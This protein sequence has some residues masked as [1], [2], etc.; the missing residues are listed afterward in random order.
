MDESGKDKPHIY[1]G[2]NGQAEPFTSPRGGAGLRELEY[3]P[4]IESLKDGETG[5]MAVVILKRKGY[6]VRRLKVKDVTGWRTFYYVDT[7]KRKILV[8]EIIPRADDTYELSAPHV[9]R[10]ISNYRRYFCREV[11]PR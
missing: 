8:K 7:S 11:E 6:D 1:L 4:W 9:R 10:L 5:S 2:A 3:D